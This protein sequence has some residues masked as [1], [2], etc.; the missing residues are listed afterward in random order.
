MFKKIIAISALSL[1][2]LL[3]QASEHEVTQSAEHN[4]E[5]ASP[6]SLGVFLGG[7]NTEHH[8][9]FSYGLEYVYEFNHN[10]AASVAWERTDKAHHG[11]GIETYVASALYSPY[12]N[13]WLGIGYGKEEIHGHNS[14]TEDLYRLSAAYD[15]KFDRFKV[16]P[17]IALDFVDGNTSI[18]AGASFAIMF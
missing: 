17:M 10:W 12:K 6:H 1:V 18:V 4:A 2:S 8:S 14:H 16:A 3:T 11:D 5:V 7:V 13:V 9:Y 15:Y